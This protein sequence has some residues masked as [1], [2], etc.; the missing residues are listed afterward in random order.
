MA[1]NSRPST[2]LPRRSSF[3][4]R[5]PQRRFDLPNPPTT[6]SRLI[7]L[8][9]FFQD[10]DIA[11]AAARKAFEGEWR[12]KVTPNE[13][14]RLLVK[15]ADLFEEH[16]D[17]LAAIEALDNGKAFA[18]AKGDIAAAA[19][20]LRYYGGWTDKIEGKVVDTGTDTFNYIKK[21]PVRLIMIHH[22]VSSLLRTNQY[23]RS[24]FAV[25]SFP[26][27]SPSLCGHGRSD[28][29]L[30]AVTLWS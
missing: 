17:T 11:V 26:G 5:K 20:C 10:V 19:G 13:R 24:V 16:S 1:V 14:G 9:Q 28:L 22:F 29:L 8:T 27:T 6:S 18:M 4:S 7:S 12:T 2:L 3:P 23:H 15:L 25:K 21:E 30:P